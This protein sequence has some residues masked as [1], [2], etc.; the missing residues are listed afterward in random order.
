MLSNV[1]GAFYESQR[2]LISTI[3]MKIGLNPE[4]IPCLNTTKN[5]KKWIN[6]LPLNINLYYLK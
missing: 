1:T 2:E 3:I 6:T 5:P 4:K